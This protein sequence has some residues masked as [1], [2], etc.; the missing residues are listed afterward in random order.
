MIVTAM[1][2]GVMLV[3][4]GG[5]SSPKSLAKQA[6][7]LMVQYNDADEA[8]QETLNKKVADLETKIK[9]LSEADRKLYDEEMKRL[10]EEY[11]KK[12]KWT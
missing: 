4:C 1:I 11:H 6:F 2:C 10:S 7:E 8:K 3:S 9:Q 5:G 12:Q